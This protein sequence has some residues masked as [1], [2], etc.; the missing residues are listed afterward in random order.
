LDRIWLESYPKGVP[1]F[2]PEPEFRSLRDLFEHV[3][4]EYADRPAYASFGTTLDYRQLDLLS[5]QFAGYLQGALGLTHG[6]R[7][8]VMLPNVLQ[9]PVAL[10][11]IFRA[12]LVVVNV[13]PL[14]TGR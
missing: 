7:V 12:G 2:I 13:N 9:Y 8:A 10:C 6:E 4:A 3:F 11:G 5:K 14:Y 1:A